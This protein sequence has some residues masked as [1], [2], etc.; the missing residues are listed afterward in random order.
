MLCA[1]PT[2]LLHPIGQQLQTLI[3]CLL[4]FE[5]YRIVVGRRCRPTVQAF[6]G[7]PIDLLIMDPSEAGQMDV[8]SLQQV[9]RSSPQMRILC[10]SVSPTAPA[11]GSAQP[12]EFLRVPFG[13][14]DLITK[15]RDM[16]L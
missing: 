5:G 1:R 10:V 3:E 11:L 13:V 2:I 4:E 14:S 9:V 6:A 16:V 15:V 8:S 7:R 12:I